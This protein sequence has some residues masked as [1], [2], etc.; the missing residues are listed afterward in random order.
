MESRLADRRKMVAFSLVK[1]KSGL[2]AKATKRAFRI[3]M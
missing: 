2:N 3:L 1:K